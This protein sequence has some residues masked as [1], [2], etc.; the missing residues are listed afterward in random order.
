[1]GRKIVHVEFPAQDADRAQKFWEGF[2]EWTLGV[3][4]HDRD[5]PFGSVR[6]MPGVDRARRGD[7]NEGR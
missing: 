6:R 2:G 1:M 7:P 4:H 3:L 5:R